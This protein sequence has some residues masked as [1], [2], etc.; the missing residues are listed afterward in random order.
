MECRKEQMPGHI[1]CM[2]TITGLEYADIHADKW[3]THISKICCEVSHVY[4][5][6]TWSTST[7]PG[8][9]LLYGWN[10]NYQPI[11]VSAAIWTE[12]NID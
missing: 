3:P 8:K 9:Q 7:L 6:G 2:K 5:E 4:S 10:W 11:L 12:E 1:V